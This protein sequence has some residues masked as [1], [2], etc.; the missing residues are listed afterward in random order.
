MQHCPIVFVSYTD[1]RLVLHQQ[2]SALFMSIQTSQMQE[3]VTFR[4]YCV[5]MLLQW[6]QK[7]RDVLEVAILNSCTQRHHD[8]GAATF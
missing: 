7:L 2:M 3:C 4:S 5:D 1:R 8:N 6:R